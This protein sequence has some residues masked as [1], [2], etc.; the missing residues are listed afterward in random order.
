M[1]KKW[2]MNSENN[3]S[4]SYV[5]TTFNK[6]SYLKITLDHLVANRQDDE[7]ILI[8]DGGSSDGTAEYLQG[9]LQEKKISWFISEKDKGEAHGTNKAILRARGT[10]IKIITDDDVF[11]Y[12]IIRNCK[13]WM[14]KN[15]AT[16]IVATSGG[17][18][19]Y[20]DKEVKVNL[21]SLND[22]KPN[23][24]NKDVWFSGLSI[25]FRRDALPL[26]GLLN[27]SFKIVDFEYIHRIKRLRIPIAFYNSYSFLNIINPSS[28][29]LKFN[30][31]LWK[32]HKKITFLY[33]N[34][35][36]FRLRYYF[37]YLK[38]LWLAKIGRMRTKENAESDFDY[39][40][41]F[42]EGREALK[43]ANAGSTEGF[44]IKE[45]IE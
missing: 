3:I 36:F 22:F 19:Y 1:L 21:H 6:L 14:L 13:E 9:M 11:D 37:S 39:L 33:S 26:I 17:S 42:N 40:K 27:A 23:S 32:E 12:T 8:T 44:R 31:L 2:D 34:S 10:L 30:E 5:L 25:M 29:S 43:K 7:E 38:N 16:S 15:P 24:L 4:L 20:K 41:C 18:V 45:F 35:F 28:N